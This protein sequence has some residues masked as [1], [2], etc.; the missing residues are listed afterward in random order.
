MP[1]VRAVGA[2]CFL[3]QSNSQEGDKVNSIHVYNKHS[4]S[5]LSLE[6]RLVADALCSEYKLKEYVCVCVCVCVC[7]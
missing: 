7:S 5:S 4:W 6:Q 2:V 3:E 1:P